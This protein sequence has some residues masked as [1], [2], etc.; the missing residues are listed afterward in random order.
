M[1]K[2]SQPSDFGQAILHWE[3]PEY[4]HHEKGKT[5]FFVAG[6]IVLAIIIYA[7]IV[8]EYSMA[9]V[10]ALLAGVYY[11]LHN[12]TPRNITVNITTLGI[13]VDKDFFQ[14]SDIQHFWIV[15]QPP[16]VSVLYLR[17]VKRLSSDIRIELRDQNPMVIRNLLKTQIKELQGEGENLIDKMTRWLRL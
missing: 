9:I 6:I 12:E 7:L 11:I 1:K 4:A 15:Y 16:K 5:W 8:A 2:Q 10:F 3:M 13:I 14:F 17:P